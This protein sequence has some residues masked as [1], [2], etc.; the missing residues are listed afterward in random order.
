MPCKN[1]KRTVIVRQLNRMLGHIKLGH[2]RKL[3]FETICK[4]AVKHEFNMILTW[5]GI[6]INGAYDLI[7]T[8][9]GKNSEP[10]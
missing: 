3:G 8:S 5:F 7:K 6:G 1:N 10:G 4:H 2:I 9:L